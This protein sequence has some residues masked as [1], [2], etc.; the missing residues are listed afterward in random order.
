MIFYR[1]DRCSILLEKL[2]EEETK[3]MTSFD[4]YKK[5]EKDE[6]IAFDNEEEL[7][8]M[9]LFAIN[10][11]FGLIYNIF[12]S[13]KDVDPK[14]FAELMQKFFYKKMLVK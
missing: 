9:N 8:V 12:S 3:W 5:W 7:F 10:G 6:T 14:E 1:S 2:M 4:D 13:G 11:V